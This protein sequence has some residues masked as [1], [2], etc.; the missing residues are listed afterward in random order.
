MTLIKLLTAPIRRIFNLF[1]FRFAVVA[2]GIYLLGLQDASSIG[3]AIS[4]ALDKFVA[5][6]L[7][8][9]S[10][11][12][13][14]KPF[15]S[16]FLTFG[17]YIACGYLVLSLTVQIVRRVIRKTVDYAGRKNLFG[18]RNAIARERGIEAYRA[19]E[20]LEMIRPAEITQ[21][22]WEEQF[23][24]PADNTPPY[25]SLWRRWLF[26]LASFVL[27]VALVAILLQEFTPFHALSWIAA[28]GKGALALVGWHWWPVGP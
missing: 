18:L 14:I 13:Q 19:W 1:L 6:S 16:S 8:F 5:V 4:A 10:S 7:N 27:V 23:A 11:A 3:G 26:E 25:P 20:P 21:D 22:A 12:F 17:L 9:I 28:A 15:T 2:V 24:W